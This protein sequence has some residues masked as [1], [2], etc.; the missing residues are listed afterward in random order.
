MRLNVNINWWFFRDKKDKLI[1]MVEV[2]R[3]LMSHLN[4]TL[5]ISVR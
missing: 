4:D 1:V 5:L 3:Y 2:G